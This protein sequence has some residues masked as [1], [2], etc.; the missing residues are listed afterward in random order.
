MSIN[1]K[2]EAML[3]EVQ[4][5]TSADNAI[6]K[7]LGGAVDPRVVRKEVRALMAKASQLEEKYAGTEWPQ[8]LLQ[9][10]AEQSGGNTG[11]QFRRLSELKRLANLR[12]LRISESILREQGADITFMRETIERAHGEEQRMAATAMP[13]EL[14]A[15]QKELLQALPTERESL[16]EVLRGAAQ[17]EAAPLLELLD[18]P[19]G[20]AQAQ[21]DFSVMM[22]AAILSERPDATA[23]EAAAAA[24]LGANQGA[25]QRKLQFLWMAL[26][27]TLAAMVGNLLLF[28][29]AGM[30]GLSLLSSVGLLLFKGT[31]VILALGSLAAAGVG[32]VWGVKKVIAL[33]RDVWPRCKPYVA[34]AAS[35]VKAAVL[36]VFGVIRDKV[37]RPAIQWVSQKAMP[38]LRD[39]VVHPLKRRLEGLLEWFQ[40]KKEHVEQFVRNAAAAQQQAQEPV[41]EELQ[42][43]YDAAEDNWV[44]A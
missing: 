7:V 14:E 21:E 33:V 23:E 12:N 37:F 19:Q 24:V 39:K 34:Y 13:E 2:M 17:E 8:A 3:Q 40:K 27:I 28:L 25:G 42:M 26:P 29:L 10:V 35:K 30:A 4:S 16:R 43:T 41:D 15:L 22:A 38:I 31:A 44:Y 5:G 20:P 1:Q 9:E 6:E 11:E 36:T 32:A 18:A